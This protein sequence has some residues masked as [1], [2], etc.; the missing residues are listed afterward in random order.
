MEMN[1]LVTAAIAS[2]LPVRSGMFCSYTRSQ[3]T[4][5]SGPKLRRLPGNSRDVLAL[6]GLEYL[7]ML[8]LLS[9]VVLIF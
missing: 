3:C 2:P 9:D 6:L 7:S 5:L 1:G 8:L 4:P